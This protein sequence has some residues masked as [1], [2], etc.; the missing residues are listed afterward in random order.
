MPL[1][2]DTSVGFSHLGITMPNDFDLTNKSE[3]QLDNLINNH[4]RAGQSAS[5]TKF[6]V[7][8]ARRGTATKKQL[9]LLEWNQE[10]VDEVFKPFVELT[11]KIE[12]NRRTKYSIA[13]G[14]KRKDISD[15]N[16]LWIDS[17]TGVK[18]NG[19][20]ATISCHV[21]QPGD[22]PA[23]TLTIRP[24]DVQSFS[25]QEL[26]QALQEWEEVIATAAT[27]DTDKTA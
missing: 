26:D 27:L 4:Q 3:T 22:E 7:E 23:F 10:R 18:V 15:P 8:K 13:G 20:N 11:E 21:R 16:H 1:L 17:Y 12:N 5:V 2:D 14:G 25:F 9:R 19:L 6:V 24:D